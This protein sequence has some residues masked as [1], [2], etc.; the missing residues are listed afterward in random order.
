MSHTRHGEKDDAVTGLLLAVDEALC[1]GMSPEEIKIEVSAA[2]ETHPYPGD[3]GDEDGEEDYE[4]E[5]FL[6]PVS[7][8]A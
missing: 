6:S 4:G 5:P 8:N 3:E 2:I 7:G 1:S